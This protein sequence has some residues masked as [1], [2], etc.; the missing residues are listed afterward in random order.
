[1]APENGR[2][3]FAVQAEEYLTAGKSEREVADL[4][5]LPLSS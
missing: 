1:M 2:K 5:L 4:S 3:A